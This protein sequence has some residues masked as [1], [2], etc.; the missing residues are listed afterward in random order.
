[1][2]NAQLFL[3]TLVVGHTV[4]GLKSTD[5]GLAEALG[6]GTPIRL[7]RLGTV[8]RLAPG[9][10]GGCERDLGAPAS[11]AANSPAQLSVT[12]AQQEY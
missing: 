9:A 5:Q 4:Q 12:S 1:L 6:V 10:M 3:A 2:L 7:Y 11:Q 8:K